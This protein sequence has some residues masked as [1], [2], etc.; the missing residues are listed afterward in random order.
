[1]VSTLSAAKV[2][3]VLERYG[4]TSNHHPS[5]SNTEI[6]SVIDPLHCTRLPRM[7]GIPCVWTQAS[8]H[9]ADGIKQLLQQRLILWEGKQAGLYGQL[10]FKSDTLTSFDIRTTNQRSLHIA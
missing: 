6:L 9:L 2:N 4:H 1:M 7:T 5:S 10:N 8:T 3:I